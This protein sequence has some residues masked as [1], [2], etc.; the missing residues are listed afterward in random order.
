MNGWMDKCIELNE[1]TDTEID[2][3][4]NK[5]LNEHRN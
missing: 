3:Q 5:R 1:Y 2:G 4:I